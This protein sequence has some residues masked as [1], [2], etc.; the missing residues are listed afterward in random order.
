MGS[1]RARALQYPSLGLGAAII[2]TIWW[3][4]GKLAAGRGL[5]GKSTASDGNIGLNYFFAMILYMKIPL[6]RTFAP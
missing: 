3:G 4:K 6:K 5:E 1:A 2:A